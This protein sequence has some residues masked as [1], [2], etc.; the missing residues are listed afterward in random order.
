MREIKHQLWG[1]GW[2]DDAF[3]LWTHSP[4]NY[5]SPSLS[6]SASR[7]KS[8]ARRR[9]S[10]RSA[11]PGRLEESKEEVEEKE[12][13][14]RLRRTL[15][16]TEASAQILDNISVLMCWN[17]I[18]TKSSGLYGK[19][20]TELFLHDDRFKLELASSNAFKVHQKLMN[21]TINMSCRLFKFKQMN[22]SLQ[23]NTRQHSG[24]V[25]IPTSFSLERTS[26]SEIRLC[27]SRRSS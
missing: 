25:A 22:E 23:R 24:T 10:Q 13:G 26:N 21:I 16:Q 27:P 7:R 4:S 11:Q 20:E 15:D 18:K 12:K 3:C 6:P 19:S 1:N 5:S 8:R 14:R 9:R 17:K 2:N